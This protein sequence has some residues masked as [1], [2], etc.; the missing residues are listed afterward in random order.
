MIF[1]ADIRHIICLQTETV[2][3]L[4][5]NPPN[6]IPII[7]AASVDVMRAATPTHKNEYRTFSRCSL[8]VCL[9]IHV[10]YFHSGFCGFHTFQFFILWWSRFQKCSAN[11]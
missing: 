8:T 7:F 6:D 10:S 4:N 3:K 9:C 1:L 11:I 5:T 2:S